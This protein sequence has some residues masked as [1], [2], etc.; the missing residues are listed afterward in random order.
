MI[1]FHCYG[2]FC[3]KVEGRIV[4]ESCKFC[5]FCK[6]LTGHIQS[7]GLDP[8]GLRAVNSLDGVPTHYRTLSHT[9]TH[10]RSFRDD[11]HPIMHYIFGRR[12]KIE[13]QEKTRDKGEEHTSTYCKGKCV[14]VYKINKILALK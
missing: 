9:L 12:R 4:S 3:S 5:R 8:R 13:N 7:P 1:I 6:P 2:K 11:V 14:N 10:Q